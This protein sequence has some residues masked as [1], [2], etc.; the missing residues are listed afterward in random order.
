MT[1]RLDYSGTRIDLDVRQGA[2][3]VPFTLNFKNPDG[4]AMDLT[5]ATVFGEIRKN[6]LDAG[7]P[8]VALAVTYPDRLLGQVKLGATAAQMEIPCG[9]TI[10]HPDSQYRLD[11][12]V[13]DALLQHLP[14][15]YGVV[16]V[17]AWGDNS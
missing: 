11:I 15:A 7:V 1:T 2:T 12:W 13:I 5:G 16:R 3:L 9:E 17:R 6:A 4:S 10:N 8:K 14:V